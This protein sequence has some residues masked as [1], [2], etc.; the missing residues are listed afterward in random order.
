MRVMYFTTPTIHIAAGSLQIFSGTFTEITCSAGVPVFHLVTE[1][2]MEYDQLK[3]SQLPGLFDIEAVVAP[4][5]NNVTLLVNGTNRSNNVTVTCRHLRNTIR[6]EIDT[7]FILVL[8]YVSKFD[9][10]GA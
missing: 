4:D 1:E 8:E 9:L 7:L 2:G 3:Y 6:G 10:L 5:D